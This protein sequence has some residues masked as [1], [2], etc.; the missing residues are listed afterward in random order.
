MKHFSFLISVNSP[1]FFM[2]LFTSKFQQFQDQNDAREGKSRV[3]RKLRSNYSTSLFSMDRRSIQHTQDIHIVNVM[4]HI[5]SNFLGVRRQVSELK[6]KSVSPSPPPP[7]SL[8]RYRGSYDAPLIYFM[9]TCVFSL[10]PVGA[11]TYIR[12]KTCYVKLMTMKTW[13]ESFFLIFFIEAMFPAL[14]WKH[15]K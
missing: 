5:L 14:L 6:I 12:N 13:T 8:V 1:A 9:I 10:R 7:F 4:K 11:W 15:N 2:A 3:D